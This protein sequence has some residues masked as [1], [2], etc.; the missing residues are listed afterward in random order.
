MRAEPMKRYLMQQL[1]PVLAKAMVDAADEQAAEPVQYVAHKLLEVSFRAC[2]MLAANVNCAVCCS[3]KCNQTEKNRPGTFC[4]SAGLLCS[5]P[6]AWRLTACIASSVET[7][8][9]LAHAGRCEAS[10][11]Y[12]QH[13]GHLW[14]PSNPCHCKLLM[15]GRSY[16]KCPAFYANPQAQCKQSVMLGT[17]E[18]CMVSLYC[19]C[20]C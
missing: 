6:L 20:V 7:L 16:S 12:P 2:S 8:Q 11:H 3:S 1:M 9:R 14:L 10:W 13:L 18:P 19:F 5:Q 17:A 4:L 15:D